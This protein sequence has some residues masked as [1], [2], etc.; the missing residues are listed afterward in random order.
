M[1]HSSML[2]TNITYA[3]SV[4]LDN[5]TQASIAVT[6]AAGKLV[7]FFTINTTGMGRVTLKDELIAQ[8]NYYY[9]LYANGR[10]VDTK[11]LSVVKN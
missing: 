9:T 7:Y 6:D 4:I 1:H 10:I 11:Q 5:C 2:F 3:G 8:G